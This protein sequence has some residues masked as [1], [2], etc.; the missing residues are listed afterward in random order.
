MASV[1]NLA[2]RTLSRR[3]VLLFCPGL[4]LV[5][6][7]SSLSIAQTA[8]SGGLTG[9]VTDPSGAVVVDAYV[10]I[11]N[12][13]KGSTQSATTDRGGVY[14]F[15]F[16]A[17]ARY[18]LSVSHTGFR[19]ESRTLTVLLGPPVSVNV[20]LQVAKVGASVS[21]IAEAPLVN[22]ENGDVSTTM[23]A[24][25]ISEVPNPG[26]DIT[27]I[28]QT[29]PGAIMNSD[30][31]GYPPRN[32]ESAPAGPC[33]LGL[34]AVGPLH[35]RSPVPLRLEAPGRVGIRRWSVSVRANTWLTD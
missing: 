13:S 29:A 33:F 3:F 35:E 4:L 31:I 27:Y 19:T 32:L 25:Q 6:L 12:D 17:P 9:V 28:A 30:G 7:I 1:D 11:K 14:Q 22:A 18:A 2:V 15:F 16:L 5:L 20:T 23:N 26:N 24:K 34:R 10:E 21:V 8:T